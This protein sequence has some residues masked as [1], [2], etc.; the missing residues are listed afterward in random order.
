MIRTVKCEH[1]GKEFETKAYNKRFCSKECQFIAD[2]NKKLEGTDAVTCKICGLKGM[3]LLKHIPVAHNITVEEYCKVFNCQRSDLMSESAHKNISE[4]QKQLIIKGRSHTF[5]SENNPSHGEDCKN[6]RNSPYSMN[7][8]G[9]DGLT[10]EQKEEKIQQ[11]FKTAK[12]NMKKRGNDTTTIEYYL[13]RGMNEEEA[14]QA[15]KERQTTFTLEKCIERY[16]EEE[17]KRVYVERQERWQKTLANKPIE[18]IERINRAKMAFSGYSSISQKL[19]WSIY[20]KIKDDYENI[21]FA[22]LNPKTKTRIDENKE[23]NKEYFVI[24]DDNHH[25]FLDFYV[26]DINKVIEFDG[27]YWHGERRGNQERDKIREEKLKQLGFVNVLH[28]AERDY[29][30]SPEG[31]MQKCLEY[32]KKVD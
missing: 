13:K 26:K 12:D 19:F 11:L 27:D 25:F 4:S 17:G 23:Y 32:L 10:D 30:Q 6:G 31:T 21:Y 24:A 18:E 20:E 7:F 5:T 14:R 3:N 16:G 9:Y 8:R 15:L 29:K 1:C 22:T 28:I 2:R